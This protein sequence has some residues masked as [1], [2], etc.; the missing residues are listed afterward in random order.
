MTDFDLAVVGGGIIGA[1]IAR[2]AAGRGIR[3]VL[4]ERDDLA[5]APSSASTSLIHGGLDRLRHG[6]ARRLRHML[7]ERDVLLRMAPHLVRPLRLVLPHHEGLRPPWHWQLRLFFHNRL[8]GRT[9]LPGACT[10]DLTHSD[11]GVPLK[12]RFRLGFEFSGCRVDDARLVIVTAGDAAERGAMILTRT[13]LARADRDGLAWRLVLNARGRRQTLTARVLVNAAGPWAAEVMERVI[14]LANPVP[15]RLVKGCHIVVHRLFDHDQAYMFQNRDGRVLYAIPYER[16]FTLI[17]PTEVAWAGHP[18]AVAVEP[19]EITYLCRVA[20]VHFR[21]PVEPQRVVHAF[22]GVRVLPGG[23]AVSP[24]D[25]RRDHRLVLDAPPRQAPLLTVHGGEIAT[26]R[27]IAEAAL[28]TLARHLPFA[29][30]WTGK[31]PLPGGDFPF[32]EIAAVVRR[33]RWQ[34]PFLSESNLRRLVAA[35][36]TR[37]DQV[38]GRAASLSG[39]G[40][41][42]GD[43]LT[44]AEVSHLIRREWAQSPDD[45]LWRRTRLG[46]RTGA[47]EQAALARFIAASAP[48][49]AAAE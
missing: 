15:N 42:F 1:G 46:L 47:D 29:P 40:P 30:P 12:R 38:L 14:R 37:L 10:V 32:D 8:G 26:H 31:V 21:E 41:C 35:Y 28:A 39:L 45:V 3:T 22:A 6:E 34:W 7:A 9:L 18:D 5:A 33:A 2:D 44:A 48:H 4:V 23:T 49:E 17:G 24:G 11:A 20:S 25:R 36:G 13:R 16:D 27:R 19:Q 43:E